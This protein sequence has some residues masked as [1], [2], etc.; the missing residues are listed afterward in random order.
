MGKKATYKELEK[1]ISDLEKDSVKL[2]KAEEELAELRFFKEMIVNSSNIFVS[3]MDPKGY[4]TYVNESFSSILGYCP[5]ELTGLH[6]KDIGFHEEK[7]IIEDKFTIPGKNQTGT[8][9]G[10]II[11]KHRN[12]GR[13]PLLSGWKKWYKDNQLAGQMNIYFDMSAY[14]SI[15]VY[16]STLYEISKSVSTT[17]NLDDLFHNIE[18]CLKKILDTTYMDIYM[19]NSKND[20]L[21]RSFTQSEIDDAKGYIFNARNSGTLNAEVLNNKK[22]LLM[23][24]KQISDF[25]EKLREKSPENLPSQIVKIWMGAPLII[26]DEVIGVISLKHYTDPDCYTYKDLELLESVSDQIALAVNLKQTEDELKESEAKFRAIFNNSLYG[27]MLTIPGERIMAV[28]P[29]VCEMF[30][31]TE[32]E[33]LGLTDKKLLMDTD[34][35]NFPKVQKAHAERGTYRGEIV[36]RRKD[37]TK[38]PAEI[39]F[40]VFRDEDGNERSSVIIRDISRQKKY[41]LE[42]RKAHR[43]LEQR[44]KDRTAELEKVNKELEQ[45]IKERENAQEILRFSEEK[46]SKAFHSSPNFIGIISLK[47]WKFIEVNDYFTQHGGYS[48]EKIIGRTPMEIK[49]FSPNTYK[50]LQD[51]VNNGEAFHDKAIDFFLGSGERR[52]GSFSCEYINIDGKPCILAVLNDITESVRIKEALMESEERYRVLFEN[53]PLPISMG[54]ESGKFIA[55][56][57]AMQENTGYS[58]E[59]L[60]R[61]NL[62]VLYENPE[63]RNT[64]IEIA[65]RDNVAANYP[66]RLKRK[67][68]TI[69]DTLFTMS[70]LMRMGGEKIYQCICTDITERLKI[71]AEKKELEARLQESRKMDAIAT[72]A[73]GIAHQFNNALSTILGNLELMS[74]ELLNNE[75]I[76]RH[77]NPMKNSVLNMSHWNDQLLA[78]ARGGKYQMETI[79]LVKLIRDTLPLIRY[80]MGSSIYLETDLP[81]DIMDVKVDRLQIQTV[82]TAILSNAVE[83]IKGDGRIFVSCR[84]IEITRVMKRDF[85]DLKPGNYVRMTMKDE[86]EGMDENAKSRIFEPFFST[87]FHGRGLGMAAAYGIITNHNGLIFIESEKGEGTS[88]HVLLPAVTDNGGA[89]H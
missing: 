80:T 72:L 84:N 77:I 49:L 18:R 13:V 39:S 25:Y 59:E 38:F 33:L 43:E 66:V 10:Q 53:A 1:R 70:R 22:P 50:N 69:I 55:G 45:Q 68:G 65:N 12:G 75:K 87:K 52:K 62:A 37:G 88:V 71:E 17:K 14:E 60:Q 29:P 61:M 21:I 24:H 27:V 35:P 44:V 34:D 8:S 76:L 73:G 57:R 48:R 86:G 2:Q 5:E 6:W 67:D 46:F 19:Y 16:N 41:E 30:G 85:P 58:L 7:T 89:F 15:S 42:L 56:N 64:L 82:I 3:L 11:L 63:E 47:D 74:M 9:L 20:V 83:S 79:S 26:D 28:N 78:Y 36:Y 54:S 23:R 4:Y 31:M 32:E 51:M 81:S 40:A